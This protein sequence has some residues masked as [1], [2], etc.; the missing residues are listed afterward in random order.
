MHSRLNLMDQA[1]KYPRTTV[2]LVAVCTLIL[3][4]QIVEL[5]R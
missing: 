4:L 5:A 2:Y 1:H 3:L